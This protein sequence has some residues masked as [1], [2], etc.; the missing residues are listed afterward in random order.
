MPIQI[1][2]LRAINVG[3]R[4]LIAMAELR[5]LFES[6][7]F[8]GV[9]SLLQSGNL[10][11][12]SSKNSD[13]VLERRLEAETAKRFGVAADYL[14]RTAREWDKIIAGNPFPKEAKA[15][16][17]HLLLICLK[18]EPD[19]KHVQAL[20]AAIKGPEYIQSIG[21]DLYSVYPDGIGRSKLTINLIEKTLGTRGTGRNWNTVLKLAEMVK[22]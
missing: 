5:Q 8:T 1:A 20:Q 6:L 18:S 14:V 12:E 4:N 7:G 9:K 2:L 16:P 15:D 22:Q 19:P 10:V 13:A 21:N 11:F 17:S 3:G